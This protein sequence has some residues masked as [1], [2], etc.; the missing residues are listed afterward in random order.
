MDRLTF[1]KIRKARRPEGDEVLHFAEG[2]GFTLRIMPGMRT[3]VLACHPDTPI[4]LCQEVEELVIEH[5][6]EV[7]AAVAQRHKLYVSCGWSEKVVRR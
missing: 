3:P 5:A 6:E 4:I 7:F 1:D 2:Q